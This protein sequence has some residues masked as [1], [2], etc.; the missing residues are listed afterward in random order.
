MKKALL[1]YNVAKAIENIR[2]RREGE[3]TLFNYPSI[4][5]HAAKNKD[6][7][8][9]NSYINQ[10]E[11][12]FKNYFNAIVNGFDI[13]KSPKEKVKEQYEHYKKNNLQVSANAMKETLDLLGV[14]IEGVNK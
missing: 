2:K 1:P 11:E 7:S 4:A 6:Y 13:E 14:V 3:R 5:N 8:T 12:N 10:S 9:I